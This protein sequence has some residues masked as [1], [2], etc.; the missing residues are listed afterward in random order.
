MPARVHSE[1]LTIIAN[2]DGTIESMENK[3]SSTTA[4]SPV[5]SP[6]DTDTTPQSPKGNLKVRSYQLKKE[7]HHQ[8]HL[9]ASTVE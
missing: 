5:S 4:L 7:G 6:T 3:Q 8:E 2:P 9:N 1:S